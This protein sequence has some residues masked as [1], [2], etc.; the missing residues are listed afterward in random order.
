MYLLLQMSDWQ[1]RS[2]VTW[3]TTGRARLTFR[4]SMAAHSLARTSLWR[5]FSAQW[6]VLR[7]TL[8][9]MQANCACTV[10]T[11]TVDLTRSGFR[12]SCSAKSG[13][14]ERLFLEL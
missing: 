10:T 9:R 8:A 14:R 7:R 11:A 3:F 4:L 5:R 12:K 1:P 6:D 2:S 13:Q